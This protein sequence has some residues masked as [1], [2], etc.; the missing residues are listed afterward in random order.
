[1]NM[2]KVDNVDGNIIINQNTDFRFQARVLGMSMVL[3]FFLIFFSSGGKC[4]A[5]PWKDLIDSAMTYEGNGDYSK[6]ADWGLKALEVARMEFGKGDSNYVSTLSFLSYIFYGLGRYDDAIKYLSEEIDLTEEAMGKDSKGY[7]QKMSNL[8][9]FYSTAARFEEAG[10][11]YKEML[12][13]FRKVYSG[14]ARE[15]A[16]FLNNYGK[17]YENMGKFEEEEPLLREAFE[18]R[19]RLDN[20]DNMDLAISLNDLG[21]FYYLSGNFARADSF[22]VSGLEM[23]KRI[24]NG[25]N[26]DLATCI[27]NVA[28]VYDLGGKKQDAERLYLEAFE[29]RKRIYKDVHPAVLMSLNNL[30]GF[31][32]EAGNFVKAEGYYTELLSKARLLFKDDNA[33]FAEYI[34]NIATFYKERGFYTQAEPLYKE[35]YEMSRRLWKE[36]NPKLSNKINNMAC[37]Y[38]TMGYYTQAENLFMEAL[39]MNRRIYKGDNPQLAN[40][41]L[42]VAAFNKDKGD[43][44]LAESLYIEALKM[45]R[46]LFNF[47]NPAFAGAINQT[48]TFYYEMGNFTEAE[49]L[50]KES[51]E[52]FRRLFKGNDPYLASVI[53]N[54]GEL[55]NAEGE[56]KKAEPFYKEA[57]EMF[58]AVYLV[59]SQELETS[60]NN[61]AGFYEVQGRYP[62][63]ENLYIEAYEMCKRMYK[64]DN[65]DYATS[66]NNLGVFYKGRFNFEK[67][68]G[69]LADGLEMFR[70]L[71]KEDHPT[72]IKCLNN[73]A[74]NYIGLGMIDSANM[75]YSELLNDMTKLVSNYFPFLSENEKY[76]FHAKFKTFYE[77]YNS[78][79]VQYI[80]Q[81]PGYFNNIVNNQI[82]TKA[83]LLNS[84]Q[85][86]RK[87]IL[88]N[89]D[90]LLISSYNRWKDM[91]EF[92]L[93]LYKLSVNDLKEKRLNVDSVEKKVNEIE[94]FISTKSEDFSKEYENKPLT[95]KDISKLLD[96]DEAAIEIVRFR[97]YDKRWTDSVYYLAL[98]VKSERNTNKYDN[99][100]LKNGNELEGQFLDIYRE[101]VYSQRQSR[102]DQKSLEFDM[103]K[104]YSVFWEEI[105]NKLK[106]IKTV[107]FSSDGVF[108]QINV[109]NFY[110]PSTNRYLIEDIDIRNI[111]SLRDIAA[112][113]SIKKA[114]KINENIAE[115]FGDP[116]FNSISKTRQKFGNLAGT[117]IEI[118][119]IAKMLQNNKW[120]VNIHLG[121]EANEKVIKSINYPRILHLATHG[122]FLQN[123]G[124][125]LDNALS[126]DTK[127]YVENPLLKSMLVMSGTIINDSSIEVTNIYQPD[128]EDGYLTAY[129]A[130]NLNLNNTE[131]VVLSACETGLG[132][133]RNGEGVYGLQRAF[134][135]AGAKTLIM[136]LWSVNDITTQELMTSF[137]ENWLSGKDKHLAFRKAQLEVKKKYPGFYYWGAFVMVGE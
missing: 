23:M 39:E 128:A 84:S 49:K 16:V 19:K 59:D 134:I 83:I 85:R 21:N 3:I 94:K 54:L 50:F 123:V 117:R 35:A 97:Y 119:T 81:S 79:A 34:G 25:D 112:I 61:M 74:L 111:T 47:D 118:D 125:S 110:N 107:Y 56:I 48:G 93:K 88:A 102:F 100:L 129:E 22:F 80:D 130:M 133:I 65:I 116:Q 115:L 132:E 109:Q 33:E 98:I 113:K 17:Y 114:P 70:R 99:V 69:Y 42:N 63:A 68:K 27:N 53:N 67:A 11:V 108:N 89:N 64:K 122:L 43:Y 57:L 136:S 36:D 24:Y 30:G 8:A 2:V 104:L 121:D 78:F 135:Q 46:S 1:M 37:F 55:Y 41:I 75:I 127:Y 87:N 6:A 120:L 40:C 126:V 66:M 58:R 44:K 31:Y 82:L 76:L 38:Q 124:F 18:M 103:V 60:V 20:G 10:K 77:Q 14:D 52:M 62:E 131:L 15:L 5:E 26:G 90:T 73:V 105:Q 45:Y 101:C 9:I 96:K 71:F 12:P 4:L 32:F 106:G 28:F 91:R 29:M 137:Y 86:L 95:L 7:L 72:I 13:I 51:L 92:L